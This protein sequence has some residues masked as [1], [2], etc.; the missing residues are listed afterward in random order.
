M[1]EF[2]AIVR[3]VGRG[4][5]TISQQIRDVL[6]ID[7]GDYVEIKVARVEKQIGETKGNDEALC[8]V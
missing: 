6:N 7:D 8:P 2:S 5:I 1:K 3:L 4:K